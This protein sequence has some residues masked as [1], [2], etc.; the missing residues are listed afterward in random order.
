MKE[1]HVL[2]KF[3]KGTVVL[4]IDDGNFEDFR[5]YQNILSKFAL[6]ATLNIITSVIG[7]ATKLT[8]DQLCALYRDPLIEI[9]AH[10]HTHKNDE[11]DVLTGVEKLC[12]WLGRTE[13]D[14]GFASPGSQ[15]KNAWIE[16]NAAHLKALGLLYVRTAGNPNPNERHA[17]LQRELQK[18]GASDYVLKNIPQL[19][20]SFKGLSVNSVV[21]YHHTSTDDLKKLVDLAA[22]EKACIVL[23]FHRIKKHGETNWDG[24]WCYDYEQFGQ[25]AEFLAEKRRAGVVDILTNRQAYLKGL[26]D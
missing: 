6:S 17:E 9:A 15:M 18:E 11:E 12:R 10:G 23:M 5:V 20:Y 3:E 25:F 19:T 16:E 4:S 13:K 14:I 22:Q 7:D 1:K 21:V 8:T 2:S 24:K 26:S